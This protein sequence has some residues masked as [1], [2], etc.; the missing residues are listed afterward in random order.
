[1]NRHPFACCIIAVAALF[2]IAPAAVGDAPSEPA[3]EGFAIQGDPDQGLILYKMHCTK[4]H[5]KKG[6]GNGLM[7]PELAEKPTDLTDTELMAKMSDWELFVSIRDGSA[8][9]GLTDLMPGTRDVMSDAEA[10]NVSAYTRTFAGEADDD[11]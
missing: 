3:P 8:A 5:G 11:W 10:H 6:I 2:T 1:M 9:V 4:C 7:A